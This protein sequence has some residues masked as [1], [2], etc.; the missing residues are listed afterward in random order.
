[1]MRKISL[2]LVIAVVGGLVFTYH[3][4]D[5]TQ[6]AETLIADAYYGDLLAVKEGLEQGAPLHRTL[7]FSDEERGYGGIEF[8]AL[9]AAASGGNEDIILFLLEKGLDINATTPQGW[10]PL[11]IATRDGQA[12][13]AKLLVFKEAQLNIQTDLGA[14]PLLMAITQK[15]PSEKVRQDLLLYLLKRGADA[16]LADKKGL[17]PLF[18]AAALQN[19][20]AV[21]LLRQYGAEKLPA[22]LQKKLLEQIGK[23]DKKTAKEIKKALTQKIE[24]AEKEEQE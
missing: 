3:Q 1:M 9:H 21:R 15:F 11:F 20:Q 18:Y 12:E 17:P 10:T 13:A 2:A 7:Y 8:N 14:T 19:A 5:K 6:R 22:P 24:R 23:K 16:N 4:A